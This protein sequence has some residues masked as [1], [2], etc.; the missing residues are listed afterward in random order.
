MKIVKFLKDHS[1]Y[2]AGEVAEFSDE[3]ADVRIQAGVAELV[4]HVRVQPDRRT[5]ERVDEDGHVVIESR[6][7]PNDLQRNVDLPPTPAG[8]VAKD[9]EHMTDEEKEQAR[10]AEAGGDAT[11]VQGKSVDRPQVN[12]QVEQA[13]KKK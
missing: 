7:V 4:K 9:E 3:D 2:M 8:G 5:V 11:E 12:K 1:P 13:P 10:V 6:T